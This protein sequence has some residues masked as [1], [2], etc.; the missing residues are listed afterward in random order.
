MCDIFGYPLLLTMRR[1][2]S[3]YVRFDISYGARILCGEHQIHNSSKIRIKKFN[4]QTKKTI[5]NNIAFALLLKIVH[6]IR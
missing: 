2:V 4:L 5:I 1:Y 6:D 3:T